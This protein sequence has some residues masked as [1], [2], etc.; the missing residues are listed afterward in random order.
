MPATP[1]ERSSARE[2]EVDRGRLLHRAADGAV[3]LDGALD[4]VQEL[5]AVLDAVELGF[6]RDLDLGELVLVLGVLGPVG[7]RDQP[8]VLARIGQALGGAG[9]NI[10]GISAFTGQGKGIIH[11]LVD[12]P[13]KAHETLVTA[14]FDVKAARR[15]VTYDVEDRPGA[16]GE[17]CQILADGGVN[18]EQCYLASGHTTATRVVLVVDDPERVEDGRL[19]VDHLPQPVVG[20]GDEGIGLLLE[21]FGVLL[22]DELAADSAACGRL[23]HLPPRGRH[24]HGGARIA[25]GRKRVVHSFGRRFRRA[26]RSS[27]L[28]CDL[29]NNEHLR[30]IKKYFEF[31]SKL[32]FLIPAND[33]FYFLLPTDCLGYIL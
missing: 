13:D 22:R 32:I 29:H 30:I 4:G 27:D 11:L 1:P 9:V 12:E 15:V 26:H 6:Q 21:Q 14:G 10:E 16:L 24:R 25:A 18:I 19:L 7:P 17:L 2:G 31:Q 8:G 20:D 33:F 5:V 23:P 28:Q 3:L